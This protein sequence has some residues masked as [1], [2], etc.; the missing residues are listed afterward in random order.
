MSDVTKLQIANGAIAGSPVIDRR[1]FMR[2][3]AV[4]GLAAGALPFP[5]V[6]QQAVE[7]GASSAGSGQNFLDQRL[8]R[9][10]TDLKYEDLP[11][12]VVRIV[13]RSI[14]D[15]FGCAFGG[16]RYCPVFAV[17]KEW[18][19]TVVFKDE[20]E[21]FIRVARNGKVRRRIHRAYP[22]PAVRA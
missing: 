22:L 4:V 6:A 19:M 17:V 12:D 1:Y 3:V 5:A 11:E 10:A 9:Y 15:T 14:L 18:I 7:Q 20:H 21:I 16:S 2:Q 13:K 8:A